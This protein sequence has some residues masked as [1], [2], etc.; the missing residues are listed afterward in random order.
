MWIAR[1]VGLVY[2]EGCAMRVATCKEK[3]R[4]RAFEVIATGAVDVVWVATM[5]RIRITFNFR[6]FSGG[7]YS[8]ILQTTPRDC[9]LAG[10]TT[11]KYQHGQFSTSSPFPSGLDSPTLFVLILRLVPV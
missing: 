3:R 11:Y 6:G 1:E 4:P 10:A 8:A 2:L 5:K 9:F 7:R